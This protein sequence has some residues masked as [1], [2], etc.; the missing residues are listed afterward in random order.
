MRGGQ[1]GSTLQAVSYRGQEK[2]VR[3]LLDAGADA[4][5]QGGCYD[6][7]LQAAPS[8]GHKRVVRVLLNAGVNAPMT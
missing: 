4:N 3:M 8:C 2:V 6:N 5:A 1:Y 7:T